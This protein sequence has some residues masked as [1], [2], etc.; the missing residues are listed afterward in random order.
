MEN[1][2][3]LCPNKTDT[4]WY[5]EI[6]KHTKYVAAIHGRLKY[7]NYYNKNVR[8]VGT[9]ASALFIL[10]RDNDIL[11][12]FLDAFKDVSTIYKKMVW[13]EA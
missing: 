11:S 5:R 1:M 3:V 2:I 8:N 12:R 4:K 13:G 9:F 6:E 7:Q 10:S